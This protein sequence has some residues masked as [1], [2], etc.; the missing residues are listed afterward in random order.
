MKKVIQFLSMTGLCTLLAMFAIHW[1]SAEPQGRQ[2]IQKIQDIEGGDRN[3][4]DGDT[5]KS[6]ADINS[7]RDY[8]LFTTR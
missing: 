5:V 2:E 4:I 7:M 8:Y 1:E 3:D 6:I